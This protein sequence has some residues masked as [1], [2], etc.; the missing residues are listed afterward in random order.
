[1]ALDDIGESEIAVAVTAT[2][3]LLFSPHVRGLLRG[4][5]VRGLAGLLATS[6]TLLA[7]A[8]NLGHGAA[9]PDRVG[10]GLQDIVARPDASHGTNDEDA[11]EA[12][13]SVPLAAPKG[14]RRPQRRRAT[15]QP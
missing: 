9:P 3:A 4:A 7:M 2:T 13:S 15:I 11:A 5:A 1:M 8:R 12:T 14:R 6:D 10:T